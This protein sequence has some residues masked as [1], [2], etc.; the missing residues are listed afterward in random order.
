MTP[1]RL[2]FGLRAQIAALGMGGVLLLGAIY[3]TGLRTQ[4]RQQGTADDSTRL[5]GAVA[6]LAEDLLTA[7]QAETEFLLQRRE[8]MIAAREARVARASERLKEIEAQ[9]APLAAED[10]IK[11]AEAIRAG[12]NV[13]ET[14]FQ[15]VAAAQRTLG[16][17]ERDGLQASLRA[18]V[19]QIETRLAAFDEPRLSVLM[20]MMRRHEKDFMLRGDEKYGDA[21]RDRVAEF[22]PALAASTLAPDARTEIDGLLKAYAGRFLAY[23]AGA[24]TL[25]EEA[26]DLAAIY[27]RLQPLVA[28][29]RAAVE[30]RHEQTLA[31][32]AESRALTTALMW[33]TIGLTVL[34]AG[35]LSLW[36][37]RRISTPLARMAEAMQRLAGGDLGVAVPRIE[38]CDEI[39][40]IAR[41]F[42]VFHA[43]IVENRD[44]TEGQATA[45]RLGEAERR[46]AMLAL[47]DRLETEVGHAAR[48][49]SRAA[50]AMRDGAG[51]VSDVLDETRGR[52]GAAATAS[53]EGSASIRTVA[54][55]AEELTASLDAVAARVVRSTEVA[56][57]AAAEAGRTD[58][59]VRDLAG[60]AARI[61]DVVDLIGAVAGQTN[62]L[63]LNA[64][65]EAARAGEAGRGFAVVASEVKLLATQTTKAT[66]DIRTQ[67]EAI[68][69]GTA[70]V[71]GAIEGIA[72]TVGEM[73]EIASMIAVSVRQQQGATQE[74][75]GNVAR[76]AH[77]AQDISGNI[78]GVGRDAVQAAEAALGALAA[79]T[80]VADRSDELQAA[81]GRFLAEV[82][83]A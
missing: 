58:R 45:R 76:V 16:F 57:R 26:D 10:P 22:G 34:S 74:I 53:Q 8:P 20:L 73:D 71:V 36:V 46:A 9:V 61:G 50:D 40:A 42:G 80:R 12:L 5:R 65:I 18:A 41:A 13:Y 19:H 2:R 4:E 70:Q 6:A 11:R 75:A 66:E 63:A 56:A 62:L 49:L 60:M 69:A 30:A 7:R 79:A 23:L 28:E 35:A 38:R 51:T 72:G 77:G 25:K 54:T 29:V 1:S 78:A 17:T 27:G 44:L 21:L 14:R 24:S 43:K 59:I 37:G 48:D 82:R 3:T 81:V 32:I 15:N 47:A 55:A 64:T 83:A 68:Q 52:A 67:V 31:E 39:G 33:W